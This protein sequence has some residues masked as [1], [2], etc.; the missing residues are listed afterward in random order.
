MRVID[1]RHRL[2]AALLRRAEYI[3]AQFFD[4]DDADAFVVAVRE[5]IAHGLPLSLADRKAAAERIIRS[6]PHWSDGVIAAT[7]GLAANTVRAIRRRPT[8]HSAELDVRV[9]R[10][11]K[12]RP[13][14]NADGRIRASDLL[15]ANPETPLRE[16]A[17]HAGI[18]PETA[19]DVRN[20]LRRGENPVPIKYRSG[21]PRGR[22]N[23]RRT[24][25]NPGPEPN[26]LLENLTK[27][28]AIRF[29]EAGRALLRLLKALTLNDQDWTRLIDNIPA[30]CTNEVA[31]LARDCATRWHS[32]AEKIEQN[33][34]R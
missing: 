18:S 7:T 28:P 2:R 15:A 20:R 1:G 33:R 5:N 10:D 4:G 26:A 23:N 3:E 22:P 32:I 24:A 29:N 8:P 6:H 34:S 13:L 11:G 25:S 16:I 12:V 30:H 21:C 31:E 9:G 17:R 19:R 14:R 27:D